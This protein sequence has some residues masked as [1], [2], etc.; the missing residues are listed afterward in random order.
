M[1]QFYNKPIN[2]IFPQIFLD[3]NTS[4]TCEIK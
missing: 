2:Y 3:E 4:N 1:S